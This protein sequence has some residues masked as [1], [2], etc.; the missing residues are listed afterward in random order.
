MNVLEAMTD[1]LCNTKEVL[2]DGLCN[3]KNAFYEFMNDDAGIT[4]KTLALIIFIAAI[5]G[6]IYGLIIAP[7]KRVIIETS[8]CTDEDWEEEE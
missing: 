6:L 8:A 4:R 7:K 2:V 3:V 1:T 5:L